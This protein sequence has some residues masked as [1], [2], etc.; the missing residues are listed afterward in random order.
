MALSILTLNIWHDRGPYAARRERIRAWIA[1]LSPDLI[2]FQEVLGGD[3][4][5]QAIDLLEGFGYH[6]DYAPAV[7]YWND[8]SLE[9]GNA[10][11]SRW[12]IRDRETLQLP[13][14]GDEEQR[15][16]LSVTV[17]A[18]FGPVG[19]TVTHLNWKRHHG[20]VRVRQAL[21]ARDLSWRRRPPD[22]FP[23]ILV[24]DFNA[25]PDSAEIRAVTGLPVPPPGDLRYLD[26]WAAAGE[27]N[28]ATKSTRNP[29]TR[30]PPKPERRIDYIFVGPPR[31]DGI[32][33]VKQCRVVCD[34]EYAGVWPSDHFGVYAVLQTEPST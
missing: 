22:G 21:A 6:C 9:F 26:A 23:P 5:D 3:G 18:P 13:D 27:G 25:E 20:P 34:D 11:A 28:G 17:E 16:A 1:A 30:E 33:R 19:F 12:P 31:P 32:G 7:R 14:A 8:P 10:L 4:T 24:G 2:G 29:Y 15:V